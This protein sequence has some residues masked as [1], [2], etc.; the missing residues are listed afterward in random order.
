MTGTLIFSTGDFLSAGPRGMAASGGPLCPK[1]TRFAPVEQIRRTNQANKSRSR[2]TGPSGK[3]LGRPLPAKSSLRQPNSGATCT[4]GRPGILGKNFGWRQAC[5]AVNF[6]GAVLASVGRYLAWPVRSWA[7]PVR[8]WTGHFVGPG[9]RIAPIAGN[10]T[11]SCQCCSTDI[12][13]RTDTT[14]K[15][16]FVGL[17]LS[18][19]AGPR[20]MRLQW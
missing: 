16:D 17:C 18:V 6:R 20:P 3:V 2:T 5:C 12:T 1:Y 14:G 11:A 7:W 19:R 13:A 10:L 15:E 8:S 9:R 4:L